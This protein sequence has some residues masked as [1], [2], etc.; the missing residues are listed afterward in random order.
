MRAFTVDQ[1]S[2]LAEAPRDEAIRGAVEALQTADHEVYSAAVALLQALG[3]EPDLRELLVERP[4]L[5]LDAI[6]ATGATGLLPDVV[7]LARDAVSPAVRTLAVQA[8]GTLARADHAELLIGALEDPA[9]A[10][11]G[12]A[13]LELARLETE[14]AA[15]AIRAAAERE[16]DQTARVLM[17]DAIDLIE[18]DR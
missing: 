18:R 5:V 7:Q 12:T 13:A 3:A 14:D 6:A 9:P 17:A 15:A 4:L 16:E 8:V 11:R 10:V 2:A 1:V